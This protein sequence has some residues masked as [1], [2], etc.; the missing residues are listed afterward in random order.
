[1]QNSVLGVQI[2]VQWACSWGY[3]ELRRVLGMQMCGG[4]MDCKQS[5]VEAC[6]KGWWVDG[7]GVHM[8]TKV[9]ITRAPADIKW[10]CIPWIREG[11]ATTPPQVYN[12]NRTSIREILIY[13]SNVW[14]SSKL[15]RCVRSC[16]PLAHVPLGCSQRNANGTMSPGGCRHHWSP[17]RCVLADELAGSTSTPLLTV[18]WFSR[19]CTA[20]VEWSWASSCTSWASSCMGV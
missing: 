5:K 8:W 16:C 4:N 18:N 12:D 19:S 3:V 11:A 17:C 6:L 20:C 13:Y 9:N 1:M 2:W 15:Y 7:G 10:C 14:Y